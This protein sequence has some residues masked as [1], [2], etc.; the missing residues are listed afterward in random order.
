[1][2]DAAPAAQPAGVSEVEV[3]AA[4]LAYDEA[5]EY[6]TGPID[7]PAMHAAILA[8]RAAVNP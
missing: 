7:Y 2:H 3:M 4:C 8:A 6:W 1:M 5:A